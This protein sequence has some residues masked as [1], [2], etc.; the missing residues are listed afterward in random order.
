MQSQ[1]M[2]LA[3]QVT[4]GGVDLLVTLDTVEPGKLLA[5]HHRLEVGLQPTAVHMAFV[6]HAHVLRAQGGERLVQEFNKVGGLGLQIL[7][8]IPS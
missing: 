1:R 8:G 4:Q 5:D 2:E 6:Q 7:K 3:H